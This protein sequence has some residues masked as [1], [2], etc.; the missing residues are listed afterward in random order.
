MMKADFADRYEMLV[1]GSRVLCAVSGGADS[2]CLLHWLVSLREERQLTLFAAHYEHGLRGE[3][4]ERDARFTAQQCAAVSVPCTVE[5]G[6]VL[7]FA[8]EKHIGIEE[9]ARIL[10][11]RFLEETASQLGCEK[12]ATA[13]NADDNAETVLMNLC[14][15]S[16]T[17]GMAGIPPVRGRIVR[18]LLSTSREEILTYLA[19]RGLPYIE[20]SSN[21]DDAYTRN[22]FRHSIVPLLEEEN[23]SFLSAV[24]RTAQ[25]LRE[26][27]AYLCVLADAFLAEHLQG[28]VLPA[29]E[30]LKLDLPVS[31]RVIRRLC[32]NGLSMERTDALLRFASGVEPGVLE[33]PGRK[34]TRRKGKLLF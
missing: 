23:P 6:D 2:M 3:E 22:R 33:L 5:H 15:G 28:N 20:D 1:P 10:R 7:P 34:I 26:D 29:A 30:L 17:R 19:S 8:E 4:S 31:R 16:G 12:I 25:L 24:S 27:D 32:G 21:G 11:Y 18:P 14:R 9:A 13:H